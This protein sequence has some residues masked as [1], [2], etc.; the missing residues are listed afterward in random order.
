M[1]EGPCLDSITRTSP[2][3]DLQGR[4]VM[5]DARRWKVSLDCASILLPIA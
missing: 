3:E 2:V 4:S 1:Q 5:N